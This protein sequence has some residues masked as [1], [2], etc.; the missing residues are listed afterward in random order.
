MQEHSIGIN[1]SMSVSVMT[2][3]YH[4]GRN[5]WA[6]ATPSALIVS[7]TVGPNLVDCLLARRMR[8]L[9]LRWNSVTE[10]VVSHATTSNVWVRSIV[11]ERKVTYR[12]MGLRMY[13]INSVF[14]IGRKTL[15]CVNDLHSPGDFTTHVGHP[16]KAVT[17]IQYVI[18]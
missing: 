6:G 13:V 17:E 4:L 7:T 16:D 11:S 8:Y 15:P 2:S 5:N 10:I 18:K 3:L 12:S 1:L 9:R 14:G